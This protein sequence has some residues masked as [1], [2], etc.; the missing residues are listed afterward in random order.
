ML[1]RETGPPRP[2]AAPPEA[3]KIWGTGAYNIITFG[4]THDLYVYIYILIYILIQYGVSVSHT[5]GIYPCSPS[6]FV[7]SL[8]SGSSVRLKL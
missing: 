6:L 2:G 5:H 8:L 3:P 1:H 4:T 7:L